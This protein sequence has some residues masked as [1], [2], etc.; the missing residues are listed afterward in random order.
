M[1][2]TA[3][4]GNMQPVSIETLLNAMR[5]IDMLPKHDQWIIVD[6]QGRM[7]K[8]TVEQVLPVLTSAHPLFKMPL[9]FGRTDGF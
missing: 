8:G 1:D 7:H 4:T 6:P 5:E 3:S 2:G 9:S